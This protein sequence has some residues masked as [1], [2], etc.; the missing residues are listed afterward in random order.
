MKKYSYSYNDLLRIKR[1]KNNLPSSSQWKISNESKTYGER[2]NCSN[3]FVKKST[4][5]GNQIINSMVFEL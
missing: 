3:G 5:L 1:Y 4:V 2:G